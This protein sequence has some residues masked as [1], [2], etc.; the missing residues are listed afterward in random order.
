METNV[1]ND[2]KRPEFVNKLRNG[3][4]CPSRRNQNSWHTQHRKKRMSEPHLYQSSAHCLREEQLEDPVLKEIITWME[5]SGKRPEWHDIPKGNPALITYWL[6]WDQLKLVNGVL[7]KRWVSNFDETE[8]LKLVVPFQLRPSVFKEVHERKN[9]GHCGK[10]NTI[11]R[12]TGWYWWVG[13]R[14][15]VIHNYKRCDPCTTRRPPK[16][17]P[18]CPNAHAVTERKLSNG[19]SNKSPISYD[20][21]PLTFEYEDQVWLKNTQ[22]KKGCNQ[23]VPLWEGPFIVMERLCDIVYK[24]QRSHRDQPKVVYGNRLRNV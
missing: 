10:K 15:Y 5:T 11:K 21:R 22:K 14:N 6:H 17:T 9:G 19:P 24:I 20:M 1:N 8:E 18:K 23:K 7:Y 13:W 16:K 2:D 3:Q 12:V 4:S